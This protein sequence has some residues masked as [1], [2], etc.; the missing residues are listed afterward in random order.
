MGSEEMAE[1][2]LPYIGHALDCFGAA[3]CELPPAFVLVGLARKDV[4]AHCST[5]PPDSAEL[6]WILIGV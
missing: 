1:A 4:W 6:G 3:R 2:T 5:C